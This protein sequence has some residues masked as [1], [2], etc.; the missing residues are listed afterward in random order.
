M[1]HQSESIREGTRRVSGMKSDSNEL[2]RKFISGIL[3]SSH[4]RPSMEG[5]QTANAKQQLA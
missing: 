5:S 4:S 2:M 1:N 3:I